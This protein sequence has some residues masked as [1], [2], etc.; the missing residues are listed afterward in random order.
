M[1]CSLMLALLNEFS[2]SNK[3]TKLGLPNDSH[4][5]AKRLFEVQHIIFI[6]LY[7]FF[8]LFIF[9]HHQKICSKMSLN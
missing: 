3:S 6:L 2:N 4:F 9:I 7:Y 5:T 1:C 8:T